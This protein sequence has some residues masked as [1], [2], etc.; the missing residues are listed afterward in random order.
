MARR[1]ELPK[2]EDTNLPGR[3]GAL[4]YTHPAFGVVEISHP[5]GGANVL[6]GSRVPHNSKVSMRVRRAT[7]TRDLSN[8]WIHGGETILELEFTD[9]QWAQFVSS[10]SGRATPCTFT[11]LPNGEGRHAVPMIAGDPD[12][13][14]SFSEEAREAM[15]QQIAS[16]QDAVKRMDTMLETGKLGKRELQDIR[17]T[18][19]Q[20][21]ERVSSS[22]GFVADQFAEHMDQVVSEAKIEIEATFA[23]TINSIGLDTILKARQI[24]QERV[25]TDA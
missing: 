4:K 3:P 5:S 13:R 25:E 20:G 16:L 11:E 21:A 9:A 6:F 12:A 17:N 23:N 10:H 18:V 2:I 24:E 19:A 1:E 7:M 15:Q 14:P 22:V 8:D